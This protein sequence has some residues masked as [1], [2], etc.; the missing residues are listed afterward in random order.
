MDACNLDIFVISNP[1]L[2]QAFLVSE[3][4]NKCVRLDYG[5]KYVAFPLLHTEK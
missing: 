4:I 5:D 1:G 2:V 3:V